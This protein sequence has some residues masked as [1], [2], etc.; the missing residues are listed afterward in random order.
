MDNATL[1]SI[2]HLFPRTPFLLELCVFMP[3]RSGPA[4]L[5]SRTFLR[6]STAA[7]SVFQSRRRRDG[8]VYGGG[9][10]CNGRGGGSYVRGGSDEG[11]YWRHGREGLDGAGTGTKVAGAA[12]MGIDEAPEMT[13]HGMH[14]ASILEEHLVDPSRHTI[15]SG[16][17]LG[18]N[19]DGRILSEQKDLIAVEFATRECRLTYLMDSLVSTLLLEP[20][21][22]KVILASIGIILIFPNWNYNWNDW[23]DRDERLWNHLVEN[24]IVSLSPS[25]PIST[26]MIVRKLLPPRF[27]GIQLIR[28]RESAQIDGAIEELQGLTINPLLPVSLLTAFGRKISEV[29]AGLITGLIIIVTEYLSA[30]N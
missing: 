6:S 27:L 18:C 2:D 22:T 19:S 1:S 20:E 21:V 12:S 15:M 29:K 11:G 23:K 13:S 25:S 17:M 24:G 4:V 7:C 10:G 28:R 9:Y 5:I 14:E 30:S 3:T 8:R 16:T 26:F